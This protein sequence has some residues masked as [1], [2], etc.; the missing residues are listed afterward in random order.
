MKR[1]NKILFGVVIFTALF[2]I[3]L[4]SV[5]ALSSDAYLTSYTVDYSSSM[6]DDMILDFYAFANGGGYVGQDIIK[7]GDKVSLTDLSGESGSTLEYD[8]RYYFQCYPFRDFGDWWYDDPNWGTG[9][10]IPFDNAGAFAVDI[11]IPFS[12]AM[13]QSL[14]AAKLNHDNL[15]RRLYIS[16]NFGFYD[17]YAQR[18]FTLSLRLTDGTYVKLYSSGWGS[19]NDEYYFVDIPCNIP[20]YK[21]QYIS[22]SVEYLGQPP[23]NVPFQVY[24]DQ[25]TFL[26]VLKSDYM[27]SVVSDN[28]NVISNN[29]SQADKLLDDI[30]VNEPTDADINNI[31]NHIDDA[32]LSVVNQF[33][34]NSI[35]RSSK[36]YEFVISSSIIF[37]CLAFCGYMLHGKR[38]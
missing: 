8:G 20:L 10:E 15:L 25:Y 7:Y 22:V 38:G 24:F 1:K 27:D 9:A 6:Y 31:V 11:N 26:S 16:G 21:V 30:S 33:G 36:F 12:D 35:P 14:D 28:N 13:G 2:S 3:L 32:D 4:L 29:Q 23:A 19:V 37:V 34:I 17:W 5:S 18:N